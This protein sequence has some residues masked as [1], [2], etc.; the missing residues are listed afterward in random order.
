MSIQWVP[1]SGSSVPSNAVPGGVDRGTRLYVARASHAGSLVPGKLHPTYKNVYVSYGGNEHA[2]GSGYEILTGEGFQWKAAENGRVPQGAVQGGREANGT[3]LYV[4]RA[5]V[6][7]V[8]SIGKVNTTHNSCYLPYGGKEHSVKRY[9]VLVHVPPTSPPRAGAQPSSGLSGWGLL[10]LAAGAVAVGAAA[11]VVSSLNSDDESD[12][13]SSSS[14]SDNAVDPT[15]AAAAVDKEDADLAEAIR[16]SLLLQ[17]RPPSPSAAAS[18]PPHGSASASAG[19]A[20]ASAAPRPASSSSSSLPAPECIV[21]WNSLNPPQRIH[22]CVN[23]HFVCDD[24]R[25][26]LQKCSLC[27]AGFAGRA[28]GMEQFLREL[29]KKP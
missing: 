26:Q 16:Q 13:D 7:G 11:A 28:T 29:H 5:K 6:D 23:G 19:G 21:C 14:D 25:P 2:K 22:H 4:A 17:P 18:A 15:A 24:C 8:D 1:G 20:S 10:G 3:P 27:R 12:S 9:E